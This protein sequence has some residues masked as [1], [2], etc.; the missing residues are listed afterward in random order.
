MSTASISNQTRAATLHLEGQGGA[1]A[2]RP[3]KIAT[4]VG[5]RRAVRCRGDGP[6]RL[7]TACIDADATKFFLVDQTNGTYVA[8]SS[9]RV[10]LRREA[11]VA[12]RSPGLG[13]SVESGAG[14][15]CTSRWDL[16]APPPR[17]LQVVGRCANLPRSPEAPCTPAGGSRAHLP[18]A[19]SALQAGAKAICTALPV[20]ARPRPR[21]FCPAWRSR[22]DYAVVRQIGGIAI[23]AVRSR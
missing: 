15:C 20:A 2:W 10:T 9:R 8:F 17:R 19:A 13:Q 3:A 7:A 12:R 6:Q 5:T 1:G 21:Q 14:R 16:I 11:D 23:S 4:A 22:F 18:W